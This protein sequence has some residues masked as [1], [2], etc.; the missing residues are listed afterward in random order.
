MQG[1]TFISL[2]TYSPFNSDTHFSFKTLATTAMNSFFHICSRTIQ[3]LQDQCH[4]SQT[5]IT[6]AAQ[7]SNES[8]KLTNFYEFYQ[9]R[10]VL[11]THVQKR[12]LKLY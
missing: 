3:F 8:L 9:L 1:R 12:I 10:S 2:C 11:I 7:N 4:E 5:E 6:K